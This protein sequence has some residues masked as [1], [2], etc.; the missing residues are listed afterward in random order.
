LDPGEDLAELRLAHLERV[1]VDL[2][3]LVGVEIERGVSFTCTGAKW[4]CAPSKTNP[5]IRAK[6]RA[7]SSLSWAGP[8]VWSSTMVMGPPECRCLEYRFRA[9]K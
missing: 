3:A 7:L 2:D 9:G 6:N 1:V 4:D 5:K 8:T